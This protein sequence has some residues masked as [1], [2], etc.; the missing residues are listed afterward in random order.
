M[1]YYLSL[2]VAAGILFAGSANA[3]MLTIVS[4]NTNAIDGF[5]MESRP[6]QS[7]SYVAGDH[8]TNA[9]IEVDGNYQ[10]GEAHGLLS[11]THLVGPGS[12]QVPLG[13]TVNQATLTLWLVN[14]NHNRDV[15]FYQM[16]Q[17]WS[18]TTTWNSLGGGVIP[19]V[20]ADAASM[21]TANLGSSDPVS[22][23]IDVTG[24]VS[25]WVQ[26]DANYGWG[27]VDSVNNG[28]QFAASENTTG[29]GA[30][31]PILD[32]SFNA[33]AVPEPATLSF[34]VAGGAGL[35]LLKRRRWH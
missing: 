31:T 12:G 34:L 33:T 10:G 19:G 11:F 8:G 26:G 7:F 16:T 14:D 32:V 28:I 13:A 18:E 22:V 2:I 9:V 21:I 5:V 17:P 35:L 20:N 1:R 30:H 23:S 15:Y 29:L 25:N 27:I 24:I 4:N 6:N 3:A